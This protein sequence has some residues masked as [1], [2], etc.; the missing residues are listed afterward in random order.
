MTAWDN[1]QSKRKIAFMACCGFD[2]YVCERNTDDRI[3]FSIPREWFPSVI[4]VTSAT[5][6]QLVW[7]EG[8]VAATFTTSHEPVVVGDRTHVIASF[9]SGL[10]GPILQEPGQLT[11]RHYWDLS[12]NALSGSIP[13][14]LGQLTN[15]VEL[16]F[17]AQ[18]P[19]GAFHFARLMAYGMA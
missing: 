17:Y 10:S 15:L 2:Y 4:T 11:K 6:C 8:R 19:G 16:F 12:G 13:V 1:P 7:R 18:Q 14:V 5:V 3:C 9:L